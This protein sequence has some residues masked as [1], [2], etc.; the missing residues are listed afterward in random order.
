LKYYK[1][2]FDRERISDIYS[3]VLWWV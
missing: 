1:R 3:A 2:S